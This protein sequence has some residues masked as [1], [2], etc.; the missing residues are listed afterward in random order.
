MNN[1]EKTCK[2]IKK[3]IDKEVREDLKHHLRLMVPSER[4]LFFEAMS[5]GYCISCGDIDYGENICK[6]GYRLRDEH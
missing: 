2:R 4:V 6:C 5:K 1:F 3:K